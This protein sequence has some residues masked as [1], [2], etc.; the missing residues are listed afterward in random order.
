RGALAEVLAGIPAEHPLTGVVHAAGV[1]DDGVVESLTPDR[2]DAVLRPK[3][4]A[5]WNLHELTRDM[6]L[7]AFVLFSSVAGTLGSPGQGNYAAANAYLDGLAHHRRA[8]GMQ[9]TSLAWGLWANGM[10]DG[11]SDADRSRVDR[12]GIGALSAAEGLELFDA[13]LA[14]D[15]A[16]LVPVRLDTRPRPA[17]TV[18]PM[19][20]GL[21]RPRLSRASSE[22]EPALEQRLIGLSEADQRRVLLDMVRSHAADVLGYPAREAVGT[23]T[24]FADLGFDSLTAVE[25]RNRLSG[26]TGLKL[27][28]TL[29]FDHPT[30]SGIASH[31]QTELAVTADRGAGTPTGPLGALF[32]DACEAGKVG[33]AV[34]L[35][36]A[37]SRLRPAFHTPSDVDRI[38]EPVRLSTGQASPGLICFPSVGA[39]SSPRQYARF[40]AALRGLRDVTAFPAPGFAEGERLPA[41]AEAVVEVLAEAVQRQ[42]GDGPFVLVGHSSGGWLAHAVTERLEKQGTPPFTVALLDTY[43][44]YDSAIPRLQATMTRRMIAQEETFGQ[45]EDGRLTA[46]GGYFRLFADWTPAPITTPTVFLRAEKPL[47]DDGADA[48]QWRSSWALPHAA[49]DVPGDHFTM[50]EDHAEAT[51][52]ALHDWLENRPNHDRTETTR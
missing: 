14:S 46:M 3:A 43:L 13:A 7:S 16:V 35:L 33:E 41:S 2:V 8:E 47:V 18:P 49:L 37:A 12:S 48:A 32:H 6:D 21:I 52:R 40:A 36:M 17:D 31:L 11:L 23:E 42:A 25:L 24:P 20:R 44:S 1:L 15:D 39:L 30:P 45:V 19:L 38:P 22:N 9:A 10:G 34:E 26:D 4:D 51:A 5:A 29:V 50:I 27:T 28:P